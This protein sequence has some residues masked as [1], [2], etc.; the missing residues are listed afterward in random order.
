[1]NVDETGHKDNGERMWTW[2]FKAS[3]FSLFKIDPTRSADVLTEV[4]GEEFQGVLGCDFFS[5]YRR[6]MRLF[7]VRLQFCLAHRIRG[8]KRLPALPD[9][10]PNAY[11]ERF[12]EAVRGLSRVL[13]QREQSGRAEFDRRV[14]A[15]RLE[16]IRQAT[17]GV[18][19]TRAAANLAGRMEKF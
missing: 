8:V 10:P 16:V 15:A 14:E 2:C 12:R 4:L 13:H 5:A 18:P 19:A 17:Q 3:L 11:G 9:A 6:F 1:L 7:D